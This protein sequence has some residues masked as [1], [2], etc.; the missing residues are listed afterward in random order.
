[1]AENTVISNSL[2]VIEHFYTVQGEG[3]FSGTPAYFIRLAGCDVG[4]PW[5]DTKVSW[6]IK[7]NHYISLNEII[8]SVVS[9]PSVYTVITGGE[10]LMHKLDQLC[11]FLHNSGKKTL[12]ETSG[13]YPLSGSWDWICLSP[14]KN[15]PPENEIIKKAHE[16]KIVIADLDDFDWALEYSHRVNPD[17]KLFLQ[18]EWS[19]FRRIIPLVIEFVK[20]N[21]NWKISLQLHKFMRIP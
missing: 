18:P 15:K 8:K 20:Q 1:M 14:K 4:C 6:N 3:Y 11:E 19:V 12:L 10:P 16:L 17:C 21:P 9:F 7:N 13:A 2:P 5:C